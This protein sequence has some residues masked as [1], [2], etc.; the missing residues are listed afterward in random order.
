M[1]KLKFIFV[2]LLFFLLLGGAGYKLYGQRESAIISTGTVEVTKSDITAKTNG[3]LSELYLKEGDQVTMGQLAATLGR[4]DLAAQ[5]MHD[6][7]AL[8]KAKAQL[9]DLL[10]GARPEELREAAASVA[11]ASSVYEKTNLDFQRYQAL[12]AEGAIAQQQLDNARSSSEVAQNALTCAKEKQNLLRAGNREDVI[13]AQKLE[14]ART[15]AV[16]KGTQI[17]A[18]DSEIYSP[19][20]GLVLTK[21]FERGEYVNAGSAI[22]T[23]ADT[24]DCWVKIYL[25]STELGKIRTGQAAQVKIDA[26]PDRNF[27]GQIKEISDTAEYTPRQS[28][29]KTERANMVFAV[30][31]SINNDEGILKPGLPAD[32]ILQ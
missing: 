20:S 21:N 31:I 22:L 3:Y 18:K 14:V 8:A 9:A 27:A 29:T 7:A 25:P 16:L 26:Y 15:E 24:K 11:S 17:A 23:I 6:A 12:Y 1:N 19:L 5:L 13:L 2:G 10:K 4:E 30:K 28:I 32:V